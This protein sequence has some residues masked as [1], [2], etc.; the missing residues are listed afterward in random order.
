MHPRAAATT[1]GGMTDDPI[2]SAHALGSHPGAVIV[3]CRPDAAA[4]A[5]GRMCGAAAFA[6]EI[7][8]ISGSM[9]LGPGAA[10]ARL[11]QEGHR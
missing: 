9:G 2:L 10:R 1:L 4:Y 7:A 8:P 11:D 3:D 5:A 6:R